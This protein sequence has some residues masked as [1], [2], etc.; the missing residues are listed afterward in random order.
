MPIEVRQLIIRSSVNETL[1]A[2]P[3]SAS[4]DVDGAWLRQSLKEEVLQE[5]KQWMRQ[6]LQDAKDR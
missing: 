1:P 3:A 2:K 5:C 4:D 6:W